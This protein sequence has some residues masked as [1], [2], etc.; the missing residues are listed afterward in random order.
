[1][2]LKPDKNPRNHAT[3]SDC[4][5]LRENLDRGTDARSGSGRRSSAA[6]RFVIRD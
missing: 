4:R 2:I 1:M 6:K 3:S 5:Q